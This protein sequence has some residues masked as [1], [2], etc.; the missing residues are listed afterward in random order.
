[1]QRWA[2][3]NEVQVAPKDKSLNARMKALAADKLV[4]NYTSSDEFKD[5]AAGKTDHLGNLPGPAS[6][7]TWARFNETGTNLLGENHTEVTLEHVV[8][9]VRS[10]SF[11]YEPFSV[12]AMPKGS[13][14][15]A[16]Y[17]VENKKRFKDFGVAKV[18]DKQQ[19]GAESLFPKMGF[20]LNLL[21]PYLAGTGQLGDLRAGAYVGQPVQRYL[22]IA[23]GHSKDVAAKVKQLKKAAGQVPPAFEELGRVHESVKAELNPFIKAL[24]VDGYLGDALDTTAGR[25]LLGPL[26]Q[27]SQAFVA[28]MLERASTDTDLTEKERKDLG[29]MGTGSQHKNEAIFSKWRNLHFSHA[30][31]DAVKRGVRYA[32]M[33]RLHL[34]Y[35]VAEGIPPNSHPYDMT[36]KELAEFEALTNRL[37]SS[38]KS[39]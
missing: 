20:G 29:S 34:D 30:V 11:I 39:P 24:P 22:K 5:H 38:V 23:W 6:T 19:F 2:F 37:A 35:L 13:K 10:T 21:I 31:W 28:A 27:F 8:R 1:V 25:K 14:M 33:G 15:R 17:E 7:G 4:H 36:G 9:A 16:A 26:L 12:D 32:G 3:I 18:K